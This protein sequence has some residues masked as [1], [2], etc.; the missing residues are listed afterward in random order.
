[1]SS[2]VSFQSA[3]WL[4]CSLNVIFF[5]FFEIHVSFL[6]FFISTDFFLIKNKTKI[7]SLHL[8]II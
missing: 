8:I 4:D 3:F 7:K 5:F 6:F 2:T 1:M